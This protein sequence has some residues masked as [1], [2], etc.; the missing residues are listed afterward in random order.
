ME[1]VVHDDYFGF[2]ELEEMMRDSEDDESDAIDLEIERLTE[3]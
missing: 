3:F 1:C 2:N